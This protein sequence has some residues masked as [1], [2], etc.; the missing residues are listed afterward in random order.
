LMR[1]P[2]LGGNVNPWRTRLL[3]TAAGAILGHA[4]GIPMLGE[5]GGIM[6]LGAGMGLEHAMNAANNDILS[7]VGA[8][9]ASAKAAAAAIRRARQPGSALGR[10]LGPLLPYSTPAALQATQ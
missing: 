8:K 5:A 1:M 4:T 9:A 10:I 7:R 3:G 6:G 2:V